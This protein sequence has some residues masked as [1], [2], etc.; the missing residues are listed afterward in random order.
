MWMQC[1]F[2]P[3]PPPTHTHTHTHTHT[4]YDLLHPLVFLRLF[5][6]LITLYV[7]HHDESDQKYQRGL[8]FLKQMD[9]DK[10]VH[11]IRFQELVEMPSDYYCMTPCNIPIL[12]MLQSDFKPF[13]WFAYTCPGLPWGW[14]SLTCEIALLVCFCEPFNQLPNHFARFKPFSRVSKRSHFALHR[15]KRANHFKTG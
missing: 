2:I 3:F 11:F 12:Y 9:D 14:F 6:T 8:F 7:L 4:G 15:Q 1:R 5:P 13:D 10:L